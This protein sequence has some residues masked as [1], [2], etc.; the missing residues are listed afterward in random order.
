MWIASDIKDPVLRHFPGRKSVGYF[1]AVRIRDGLFVA[2]RELDKFNGQSFYEFMRKLLETGGELGRKMVLITDNAKYHHAKLHKEWR[3]K[4]ANRFFLDFLPP[5]SQDLNPVER[6]WK[7]VR[8]NCLHN[9][10]FHTLKEVQDVVE[11][12]FR[13]WSFE[14][15]ILR[16]LCA[17][18]W[19]AMFKVEYG[20]QTS[21]PLWIST[22]SQLLMDLI[23]K[24]HFQ[25]PAAGT[26]RMSKLL[27]RS[28]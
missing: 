15:E 4:N 25:D 14:N 5:Y 19:V 27:H 22:L 6:V 1:G 28:T 13:E 12:Q 23:D 18:N 2:M 9:R 3:E 24:L 21:F 16:K 20:G 11:V 8:R 17:I 7:L 10:Y 26:R